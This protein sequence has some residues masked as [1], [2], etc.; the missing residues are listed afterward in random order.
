MI[1]LQNQL[2]AHL[3]L[4]SLFIPIKDKIYLRWGYFNMLLYNLIILK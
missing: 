4:N 1:L 2:L 3:K